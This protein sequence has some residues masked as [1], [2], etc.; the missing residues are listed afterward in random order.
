MNSG[1]SEDPVAPDLAVGATVNNGGV[2]AGKPI[3][4]ADRELAVSGIKPREPMKIPLN[5]IF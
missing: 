1:V 2:S 5:L 3:Y 4:S